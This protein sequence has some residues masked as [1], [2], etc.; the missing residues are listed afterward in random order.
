M[1]YRKIT[2]NDEEYEYTVGKSFVK[3]KGIGVYPVE[4]LGERVDKHQYNVK[5]CRIAYEIRYNNL[6]KQKYQDA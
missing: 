1:S 4:Q 3:I 2:V 6:I 5:P